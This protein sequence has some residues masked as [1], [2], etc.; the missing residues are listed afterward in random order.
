MKMKS[1]EWFTNVYSRYC[2][3]IEMVIRN[4]TGQSPQRWGRNVVIQRE[5]EDTMV[6]TCDQWRSFIENGNLYLTSIK[7]S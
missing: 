3:I 4:S 6:R 7:D 5:A 2:K 1:Y